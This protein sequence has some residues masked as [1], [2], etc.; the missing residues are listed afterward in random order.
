M[1][2]EIE[3]RL[4]GLDFLINNASNGLIGSFDEITDEHWYKGFQT[5]VVGLQQCS[6]MAA[7]LM[8][9]RG[10]GQIITLSTPVSNRFVDGF[11]CMAALKASVESLTRTMAVEFE[12]YNVAVN[13][14]SAGA[15]YGDLI[16]KFPDSEKAIK[17]WEQKSLGKKLV[18]TQ[19]IA[20]LANFLLSGAAGSIN[21]SVL[22]IDGGITIPL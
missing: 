18:T 17:Y 12:K 21:G 4:G 1:F 5:N 11:S 20:N 22:V 8:G 10:G 3:G 15:V 6:M 7:K 19:E 14:I 2:E 13:C 16:A 9:K